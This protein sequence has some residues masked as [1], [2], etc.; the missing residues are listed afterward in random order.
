MFPNITP[1]R[2]GVQFHL[3]LFFFFARNAIE[4][5]DLHKKLMFPKPPS[6]SFL[7]RNCMNCPDLQKNHVSN[8]NPKVLRSTSPTFFLLEIS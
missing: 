7:A 4:C 1:M 5:V 6:L 8:L 3:S 2:V